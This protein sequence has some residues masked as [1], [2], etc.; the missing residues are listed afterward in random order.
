MFFCL[1]DKHHDIQ[2]KRP[3]RSRDT[4]RI[5]FTLFRDPIG[6]RVYCGEMPPSGFDTVVAVAFDGEEILSLLFLEQTDMADAL[7]RGAVDAEDI[8]LLSPQ[9]GN[10]MDISFP[11]GTGIREQGGAPGV[12]GL[13]Q[14][15][16]SV[17]PGHECGAPFVALAEMGVTEVFLHTLAVVPTCSFTNT[18]FVLGY[19]ENMGT[20]CIVVTSL[21]TR[22]SI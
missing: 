7:G 4:R 10:D 9:R 8:C 17:A 22:A 14:S 13:G 11:V 3:I 2:G 20:Y 16:L 12:A 18:D 15:G 21:K 19:F 6:Q 1:A 5:A